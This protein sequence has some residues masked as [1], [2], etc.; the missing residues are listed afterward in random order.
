MVALVAPGSLTG[1]SSTTGNDIMSGEIPGDDVQRERQ[2]AWIRFY[3]DPML[4]EVPN[5][6]SRGVDFEVTVRTFGGGCIAQ[7]DTEV[8]IAATIAE[9][10]PF[11]VFVTHLPPNYACT[12]E[13]RHYLHRATLRF[14]APGLATV[15]VRGRAHPGNDMIVVEQPV[16][17]R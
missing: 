6:A 3:Q 16:L 2:P 17:V 12:S 5:V 4:V 14:M 10:R 11:D 15:R 9:V 13:L 7:G 8:T 1:C